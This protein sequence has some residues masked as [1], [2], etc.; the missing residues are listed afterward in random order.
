MMN[1]FYSVIEKIILLLNFL[2]G[3]GYGTS[4][5]KREVRLVQKLLPHGSIFIDVGGNKGEYTAELIN[6]YD[7]KELHVFEPSKENH[8]ILLKKFQNQSKIKINKKGLSNND[9]TGYLYY[10]EKGSGMASL[11][12]RKLDHFDISFDLKEEIETIRLDNYWDKNI[13]SNIVDFIK[14]DVE[15]HEMDVLIGIGKK[16]TQIKLIQFEFGGCNIDTNSFFQE[17]WYFLKQYNFEFYRIAPFSLIKIENYKETDEF[18][19]TTNFLCLNKN[20]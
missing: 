6:K 12:K 19:L 17:Y 4:S 9:S 16:I 13:S 5:I 11:T 20:L 18:F 14:I 7:Y 15:G 8:I 3:K 1:M 2:L 10:D